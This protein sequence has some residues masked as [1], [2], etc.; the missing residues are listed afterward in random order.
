MADNYDE[1]L[2]EATGVRRGRLAEALLH[3]P[4]RLRR[5]WDD[6]VG[7]HLAGAFLAVLGCAVCVAVAFVVHLL[8]DDPAIGRSRAGLPTPATTTPTSPPS[9]QPTPTT[10][11]SPS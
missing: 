6:R 5:T 11:G 3:G 7:T 9:V 2:I 4:D 10:T 8:A 1:Q